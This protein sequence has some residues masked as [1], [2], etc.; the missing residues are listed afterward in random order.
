MMSGSATGFTNKGAGHDPTAVADLS[1]VSS[2]DEVFKSSGSEKKKGKKEKKAKKEKKKK[3]AKEAKK[4]ATDDKGQS[5]VRHRH[6]V[7]WLDRDLRSAG[8]R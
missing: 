2:S 3:M 1:P 7:A 6:L 5:Q 8:L 4:R